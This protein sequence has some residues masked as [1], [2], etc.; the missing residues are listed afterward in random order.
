MENKI[1]RRDQV[2]RPCSKILK[3]PCSTPSFYEHRAVLKNPL[4]ISMIWGG[5]NICEHQQTPYPL[6]TSH[7]VFEH[8]VTERQVRDEPW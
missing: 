6:P 1:M 7:K 3:T 2:S 5:G 4:P 8:N